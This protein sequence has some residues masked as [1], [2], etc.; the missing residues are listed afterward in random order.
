MLGHQN[1]YY[2]AWYKQVTAPINKLICLLRQ[3]RIVKELFVELTTIGCHYT[4]VLNIGKKIFD[5]KER[6]LQMLVYKLLDHQLYK[7]SNSLVTGKG[8]QIIEKSFTLP[9]T[10]IQ[11]FKSSPGGRA[12][13]LRRLIPE[14]KE[15]WACLC[16]EYFSVPGSNFFLGRKVCNGALKSGMEFYSF[17]KKFKSMAPV[18]NNL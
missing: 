13:T 8:W 2:S 7:N 14:F 11:S 5:D 10:A 6:D 15:A 4:I 9:W 18:S 12:T 16:K 3:Q 17:N 1:L